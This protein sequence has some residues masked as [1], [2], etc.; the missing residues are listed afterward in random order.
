MGPRTY[1]YQDALVEKTR[2]KCAQHPLK[3]YSYTDRPRPSWCPA[4]LGTT[5]K[6]EA[7]GSGLPK[8]SDGSLTRPFGMASGDDLG[9][10]MWT[11]TQADETEWEDD[12]PEGTHAGNREHL[13][14]R[15][16]V[17]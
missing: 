5:S 3:P 17:S 10:S 7:L 16:W 11:S 2:K 14:D 8:L 9:L 6:T 15:S 13:K 1:H 4:T 12:E